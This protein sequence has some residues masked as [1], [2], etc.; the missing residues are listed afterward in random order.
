MTQSMFVQMAHNNNFS[1]FTNVGGLCGFPSVL[2]N[3]HS[4]HRRYHHQWLCSI[5]DCLKHHPF[6]NLINR[7][8]KWTVTTLKV[9]SFIIFFGDSQRKHHNTRRLYN[10]PLFR[11]SFFNQVV[12]KLVIAERSSLHN[13]SSRLKILNKRLKTIFAT[14]FVV[15]LI[16]SQTI[17]VAKFKT[18]LLKSSVNH[19]KQMF[20][21]QC[22]QQQQ[23]ISYCWKVLQKKCQ[24]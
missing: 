1:T 14:N 23:V 11:P 7:L 8:I 6:Q 13:C 3:H 16:S 15:K 20:G 19:L 21:T 10:I 12:S 24:C 2:S 9:K 18:L 22:T 5:I 17:F 4:H